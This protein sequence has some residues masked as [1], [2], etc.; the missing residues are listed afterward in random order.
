MKL[1]SKMNILVFFYVT[2]VLIKDLKSFL[3]KADY[4]EDTEVNFIIN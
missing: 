4:L 2:L 1:N 3:T